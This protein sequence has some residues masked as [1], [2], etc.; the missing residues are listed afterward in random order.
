MR[1][2]FKA[3]YLDTFFAKSKVYLLKANR[4][5]QAISDQLQIIDNK[6][7]SLVA[8]RCF[9]LQNAQLCFSVFLAW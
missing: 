1:R 3:S 4:Y 6:Q 8:A 9:G 7:R 2:C 5:I